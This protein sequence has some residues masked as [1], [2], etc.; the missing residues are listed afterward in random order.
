MQIDREREREIAASAAKMSTWR[1]T[2]NTSLYTYVSTFAYISQIKTV[3]LVCITHKYLQQQNIL[4]FQQQHLTIC[5][6]GFVLLHTYTHAR[7]GVK[8]ACPSFC[9]ACM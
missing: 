3:R 4:I 7:H 1:R 8:D 6:S 5:Y 9:F 2:K